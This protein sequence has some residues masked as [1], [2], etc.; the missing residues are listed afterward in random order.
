MPLLKTYHLRRTAPHLDL[1]LRNRGN[2]SEGLCL[3]SVVNKYD[4]RINYES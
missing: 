4:K 2:V 1:P 3:M